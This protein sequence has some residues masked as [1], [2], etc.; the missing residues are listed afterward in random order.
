MTKA[1]RS[2]QIFQKLH[3]F[4]KLKQQNILEWCQCHCIIMQVLCTKS[5][6]RFITTKN[7]SEDWGLCW[8]PF[9]IDRSYVSFFVIYL[10]MTYG[11]VCIDQR[12]PIVQDPVSSVPE[13]LNEWPLVTVIWKRDIGQRSWNAKDN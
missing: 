1:P 8:F 4:I 11:P 3:W 10:W 12:S 5:G 7:R 9:P 13:S 2:S 6:L